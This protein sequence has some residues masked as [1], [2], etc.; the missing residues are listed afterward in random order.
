[1]QEINSRSNLL[2]EATEIAASLWL[3]QQGLISIEQNFRCKGGEID[4]IMLHR[5]Q[6]V[7]VEV[8]LRS[9]SDFGSG[10]ESVTVRKQRRIICAARHFLATYA[11][12]RNYPCRFDVIAVATI[13]RQRDW[14]WF[15]N[16]FLAE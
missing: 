12:W 14:Q 13:N 10:A 3:Q 7:F 15:Q 11:R 6:L 8:R 4:L 16:A 1:M 5:D 2:G 9:R